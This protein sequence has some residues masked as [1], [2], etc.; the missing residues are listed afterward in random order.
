MKKKFVNGVCFSLIALLTIINV[1]VFAQNSTVID[2]AKL[3]NV[4]KP[5]SEITKIEIPFTYD[6]TN[7][8][9]TTRAYVGTV[10]GID[11]GSYLNIRSGPGTSYASIGTLKNGDTV[12]CEVYGYGPNGDW[13]KLTTKVNG[14]NAYVHSAYIEFQP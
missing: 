1:P 8:E 10:V 6:Q 4:V 9:A 13:L 3:T 7:R 11:A 5:A 12:I 14:Q 2:Q